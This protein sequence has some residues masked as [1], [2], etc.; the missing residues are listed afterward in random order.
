M[1]ILKDDA[2]TRIVKNGDYVSKQ[3][4]CLTAK[5]NIS[6]LGKLEMKD[7]LGKIPGFIVPVDY[8]IKDG[9]VS[10]IHTRYIDYPDFYYDSSKRPFSF[11]TITKCLINLNRTLYEGHKNGVVFL[12]FT[13]QGNLKYDPETFNVF[14]VDYEDCQIGDYNAFAWSTSLQKKWLINEKKYCTNWKFTSDADL[15]LLIN[16]WFYMST[17]SNLEHAYINFIDLLKIIGIDDCEMVEKMSLIYNFKKKNEYYDDFFI[18]MYDNYS[19]EQIPDM[20]FV[21]RFVKKMR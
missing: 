9:L 17:L 12:D 15:Y 13:S 19:L 1:Q 5:Q 11:E 21:R 7:E 3:Y 10:E 16:M 2:R 4:K 14:L 18:K 6:L 20:D 8:E